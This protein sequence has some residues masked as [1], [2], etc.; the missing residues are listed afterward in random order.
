MGIQS[1]TESGGNPRTRDLH[2]NCQER[3]KCAPSWK[4]CCPRVPEIVEKA[5]KER[6]NNEGEERKI[7]NKCIVEH[8]T[9]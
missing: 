6:K 5:I 3:G 1:Q 7:S 9:V 8:F 2:V 4:A